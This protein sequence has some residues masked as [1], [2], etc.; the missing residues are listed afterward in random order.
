MT[1]WPAAFNDKPV[2]LLNVPAVTADAIA[3]CRLAIV[4][5]AP[6]V[7]EKVCP[8]DA[9]EIDV[10]EPCVNAV[11]VARG[12]EGVPPAELTEFDGKSRVSTAERFATLLLL[13]PLPT[14]LMASNEG[15]LID[16][17]IPEAAPSRIRGNREEVLALVAV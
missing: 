6:A 8:V 10:T 15:S 2:P 17:A 3:A 11:L 14:E 12:T 1:T 9:S 4:D 16:T 5:D 7:K 13:L